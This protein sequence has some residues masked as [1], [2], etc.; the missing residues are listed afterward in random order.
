MQ[1]TFLCCLKTECI[2]F[3]SPIT[4]QNNEI[5][6]LG[7]IDQEKIKLF[8]SYY[9]WPVY[10]TKMLIGVH[11]TPNSSS[12]NL[13]LIAVTKSQLKYNSYNL[14]LCTQLH[15]RHELQVFTLI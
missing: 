9:L 6:S 7:K 1:D 14:C 2:L 3:S 8:H 5:P 10:L 11:C 12:K 13:C 4:I 15:S